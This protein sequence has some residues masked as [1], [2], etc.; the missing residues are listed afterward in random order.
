MFSLLSSYNAAR[1][2]SKQYK[3]QAAVLR[4]NAKG[5]RNRANSQATAIERAA[6]QNQLLAADNLMTARANQRLAQGSAKAASGYSGFDTGEG[7]GGQSMANLQAQ[8]DAEIANMEQSASIAMLN[9]WQQAHD[10]RRQ[11]EVDAYAQEAQ[12]DQYQMA[13]KSV[14]KSANLGLI[15]GI[16]NAALASYM[17]GKSA[18]THNANMK[19]LLDTANTSA[20]NAYNA[21]EITS[22]QYTAALFNNGVAYERNAVNPWTAA[23]SAGSN[24]GYSGF[25]LVNSFNPY[26]GALSADANNRKNNWGGL[27]SVMS[28]N[29]PYKI[30]AAG[31]IFA[32]Y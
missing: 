17:G 18:G 9:S 10:T 29:V 4:A 31:T 13:A 27:L 25:H 12:A 30:P 5:T 1:M 26:T 8:L 22:D 20:L 23:F 28:G 6:Q 32:N 2:Q 24:A 15:T 14:R 11:G 21:G 7:T 16:A 19:S 3:A